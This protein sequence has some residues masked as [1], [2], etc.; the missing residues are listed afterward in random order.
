MKYLSLAPILLLFM[1]CNSSTSVK[2]EETKTEQKEQLLPTL[3]AIEAD[4]L[5]LPEGFTYS[6]LFQEGDSVSTKE[7]E[8]FPSKGSHDLVIYLPNK[9]SSTNGQLFV[10]HE[11]ASLNPSLGH[12]GG[13]SIL[14]VEQSN[15]NW[16]KTST[17]ENINFENV[18]YTMRN[19]GGKATPYGTILM[20]EETYPRSPSE[21]IGQ[22]V[23]STSEL[24]DTLHENFGWIVEVDPTTKTP[25][26]KLTGM[27]RYSHE[28]A[29][30]LPDNKSIILTNDESPAVLFKFVADTENDYSKG[31][32]F[33][34]H[35]K[36]EHW[37]ALPMVLDSLK[38]A[39]NVAI[40]MGAT[41]FNRMEWGTLIGDVIYLTETGKDS[42]DWNE[43]INKGGVPAS[44]FNS[45]EYNKGFFDDPNG[46][47]LALDLE[48]DSL[49]VQ[50]EG[51]STNNGGFF[52]S[53]DCINHFE[54]NGDYYLIISEDII[55]LSR[56]RVSDIAFSANEVYNEVYI[57]NLTTNKVSRF[58][59]APKGSETTGLYFTPDYSTL[60]MSIQHPNTSNVTPF[61]KTSVIAIQGF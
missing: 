6:V 50:L 16:K 21:L 37:I 18:G 38:N 30:C 15:G 20:A 57:Q 48:N 56:N 32:L 58:A 19:C 46:R 25:I 35:E 10:S 28:D 23:K 44:Q 52:T 11:S 34:Y 27:G 22:I 13:A 17:I 8:S 54:W 4:T 60:F 5:T 53:P 9:G 3:K 33:A 40:N 45:L 59:N 29:I 61:N 2:Q 36:G 39:K 42:V 47:V 43:A 24:N 26:R 55:G 1:S 14:S 51:G 41:L 31:K 49:F 7:R 12:G